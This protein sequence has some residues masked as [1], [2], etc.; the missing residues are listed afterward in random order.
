MFFQSLGYGC[1]FDKDLLQVVKFWL[2]ACVFF[3]GQHLDLLFFFPGIWFPGSCV[4]GA[5]IPV[6]DCKFFVSNPHI[7]QSGV[8]SSSYQR[9]SSSKLQIQTV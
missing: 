3:W 2:C 1:N 9:G 6:E 7:K 5:Q 8:S 4:M